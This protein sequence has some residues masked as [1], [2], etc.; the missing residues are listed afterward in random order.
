MSQT[1]YNNYLDVINNSRDK[2]SQQISEDVYNSQIQQAN[3]AASIGNQQAYV[4][5]ERLKKYVGTINAGYGQRGLNQGDMINISNQYQSS[6][7]QVQM[8]KNNNI[9]DAYMGYIDRTYNQKYNQEMTQNERAYQDAI[10][11]RQYERENELLDRQFA[12]QQTLI[13]QAWER[14]QNA[15]TEEERTQFRL[16]LRDAMVGIMPALINSLPK[17]MNVESAFNNFLYRYGRQ[18]SRLS[19]EDIDILRVQFETMFNSRT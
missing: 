11:Q 18:V 2:T 9:Q 8:N 6:L 16:E 13:D 19:T 10:S 3:Q 4:L 5:N 17:S 7:G 14:E 12:N 1:T 15:R